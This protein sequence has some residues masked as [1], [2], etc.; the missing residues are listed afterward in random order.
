MLRSDLCNAYIVVKE[1]ITVEGN[2]LNNQ[3][4]KKLIFKNNTPLKSCISKTNNT[5]IDSLEDLDIVISM[6]NLLEYSKNYYMTSVSLWNYYRNEVNDDANEN[7]HAGNYK[8]KNK[9]TIKQ[10]QVNLLSIRRN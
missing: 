1:R 8:I 5:F 10:Q 9:I 6:H 4:N 7:N 2:G 3:A